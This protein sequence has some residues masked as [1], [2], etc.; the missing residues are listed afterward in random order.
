M[1]RG[2]DQGKPQH[3]DGHI[4][5]LRKVLT[6]LYR[7]GS[8]YSSR[9]SLG[10]NVAWQ[11]PLPHR[12]SLSH[13]SP[14]SQHVTDHRLQCAVVVFGGRDAL[15]ERFT[16]SCFNTQTIRC[17]KHTC[18]KR[19]AQYS[20]TFVGTCMTTFELKVRNISST[21]MSLCS[22]PVNIHFSLTPLLP[23]H[24]KANMIWASFKMKLLYLTPFVQN[25]VWDAYCLQICW[26][27]YQLL[28]LPKRNH[29]VHVV[30]HWP[31]HLAYWQQFPWSLA[32]LCCGFFKVR[33]M[34]CMMYVP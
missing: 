10:R 27:S 14:Y 20:F 34:F 12:L 1:G 22:F 18:L 9:G 2:R 25:N 3:E 13:L 15:A 23:R 17:T 6:G 31:P 5:W 11:K 4:Q 7:H 33:M 29:L 26:K 21:E 32:F 24:K 28:I 30:C 16:S 8:W 19:I